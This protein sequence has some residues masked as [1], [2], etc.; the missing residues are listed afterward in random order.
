MRG[1]VVVLVCAL[2][3]L[4]ACSHKAAAL[5]ELTKADGP[6]ERQADARGAW[7]GA[8]VGTQFYV[9]DAVRTADG[10]AELLLGGAARLAMQPHTVLRFVDSS[11]RAR[12]AVDLGAVTLA[13]S[14]SY[15]LAI[16]DVTL[17]AKGAVRIAATAGHANT[18]ELVMGHAELVGAGGTTQ[19]LQ[20]GEVVG[21]E[22]GKVTVEN[23]VADAGVRDAPPPDAAV[24]PDAAAPAAAVN[25]EIT[26]RGAE[27]LAPGARKWTRLAAGA[28]TLQPG[29]KLRLDARTTAK[30]AAGGL[31]LELAGR[32]R[33][34]VGDDLLLGLELGA[35]TATVAAGGSGEVGVPGGR[36]A[37]AA[38]PTDI[39]QARV[40]VD[41]RG[42][43]RVSVVRG[44]AKLT[45]RG[46]EGALDLARGENASVL[47]GGALRPGDTVIPKYFDFA[48]RAGDPPS[49][50][51]HDPAGATAV[52]F[53]FAGKCGAGVIELDRDARF[54]AP[55]VSA[56]DGA[57]NLLVRAGAWAYRLRCTTGSS[58]GPAVASGRILV[59]RDAG[60][61]RLPKDPPRFPIDADGR[62]YRLDY[63][64]VIPNLEIRVPGGGAATLHL[65]IGGTE[66][67]LQTTTGAFD[68]PGKVLQE[69]EYTFWAEHGGEK[70]K[71]TTLRIGFDQTAAQVYIESPLEGQPWG[72]ELDVRGA[73]LPGWT[74]KI[75][76]NEIPVDH[77]TRRFHTTLEPPTEGKALAIR[78]SH[79]QRGVHFYL[80]RGKTR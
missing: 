14:G 71:T 46:G 67:T 37:L 68:I 45:G 57:A 7:A 18:V 3:A 17:G 11:G 2:P 43:A 47:A 8:S 72:A 55:H 15:G 21:L 52:R 4:A 39:A 49:F 76:G 80:R 65:A 9:G 1:A 29:T 27:I 16:G 58:E 40:D 78:L 28:G 6:V 50:T 23:V 59:L 32:S 56:G 33:T 5:A 69:G 42:E 77:A 30:L 25:V 64:S 41:A 61:R 62:N 66:Q 48:V 70:T 51:I 53:D 34:T 60:T 10:G 24:P 19:E 22:L 35:A 36:V 13:G 74:V 20:I 12:I 54:R 75:E 63:E 44:A 26:G 79:P 38:T 73:T 31:T